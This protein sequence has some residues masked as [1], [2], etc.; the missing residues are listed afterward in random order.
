MKKISVFLMAMALTAMSVSG[1]GSGSGPEPTAAATAATPAPE[2]EKKEDAAKAEPSAES[3]AGNTAEGE[4][5]TLQFCTTM[6]ADT[7]G[8]A[9]I[10]ECMAEI[11]E[12]TGGHIQFSQNF[13]GSLGDEN[14]LL[15]SVMDGSIDLV[16]VGPGTL[17]TVDPAFDIFN[18]PFMY[19]D[20][21]HVLAFW[22]G[23]AYKDWMKEHGD[24]MGITFMTTI[25]QGFSGILNN[26]RDV[27]S[28]SDLSGLKLR[29]PDQNSLI[30][31]CNSM[32]AVATPVAASEQ[33]MSLS[34]GV[35]DG[36]VHSMAAHVSW[37]LTEIAGHFTETNHM[38]ACGM[39]EM[40]TKKLESLPEEYREILSEKFR[41]CQDT[42]FENTVASVKTDYAKAESDGVKIIPNSDV[43][44]DAFREK[45]A[46]LIETYKAIAPD[47]YEA[48]LA[49]EY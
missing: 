41:E 36:A 17:A 39:V 28:P 3:T 38:L 34:Q 4:T 14:E 8:V 32:G 40:N 10:V 1:C 22:S 35:I 24:P 31:L 7:F 47:F 19:K 29:V 18:A 37:G 49:V 48:A 26:K 45:L 5:Y 46:D 11:E 12:L 27:Y 33:Y 30:S 44:M 15:M 21:D 20:Y 23:D 2:T 6:A 13:N 43:D 16:I 25:N 9:E 42:I